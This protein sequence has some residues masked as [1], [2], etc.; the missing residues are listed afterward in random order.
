VKLNVVDAVVG[1]EGE[2]PTTGEPVQL[3]LIIAGANSAA[4]D[5]VASAVI[6]WNPMEVG[7]NYLAAR[8]GLGPSSLSDIEVV[9]EAIEDVVH[10][11]QRPQTHQDGRMFVDAYMPIEC[12]M[13]KCADCG[14]C[15]QVC[16]GG[17]IEMRGHPEFDR[18][19]CIQCFC[20]IEMCPQGALKV[21]RK[22]RCR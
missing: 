17:A 22:G 3:G 5:I 1:M 13:V 21:V 7:T 9:G 11:F 14:I 16:P 19:R 8:R 12:D 4:V 10:P 6:G 20:C 2:G 18:E 15:S